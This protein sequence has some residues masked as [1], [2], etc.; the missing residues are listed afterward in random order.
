MTLTRAQFYDRY[1]HCFS[2]YDADGYACFDVLPVPP[3][4][5]RAIRR[6]AADV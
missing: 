2:W 3:E 5:I 1:R 6:A 4:Q